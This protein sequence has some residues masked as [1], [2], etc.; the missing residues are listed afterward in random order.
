MQLE[1]DFL[2]LL[3]NICV[4]LEVVTA[5]CATIFYNKYKKTKFLKFIV[6]F[7][8]YI[9]CN[10]FLGLYLRNKGE[11]NTILYN[12]YNLINFS[13]FFLLYQ[14][15]MQNKYRRT[16]V[17]LFGLIYIFAFII[18]SLFENYF[19]KHQSI[20]YLIGAIF[21]LITIVFYFVELL[22][23]EQVLYANRNLLFW[24]S[25]GQLIYFV[26]NIPFRFLRNYYDEVT[27][28]TLALLVN[29][30]VGATMYICYIF[31]FIWSDRKQPY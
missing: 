2:F 6:F 24:I 4:G 15:Y 23:S 31:G 25:V 29:L 17:R 18:N 19:E 21:L 27:D 14:H 11:D 9:V 22:N 30:S 28:A 13:F 5:I 12:I 7:L 8:W 16:T 3:I 10:D 20:P 26:G 1:K